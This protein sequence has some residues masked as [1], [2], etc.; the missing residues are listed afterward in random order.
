[1]PRALRQTVRVAH[2]RNREPSAVIIDSQTVKTTGAFGWTIVD[3][4][5][6]SPPILSPRFVP[7]SLPLA[8]QDGLTQVH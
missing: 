8:V 1:M 4:D 2:G 5:H 7:V 6:L 3:Q